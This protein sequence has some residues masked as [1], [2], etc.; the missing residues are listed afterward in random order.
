MHKIY[1][2]KE[3]LTKFRATNTNRAERHESMWNQLLD[4]SKSNQNEMGPMLLACAEYQWRIPAQPN[5]NTNH[6]L[7]CH[8]FYPNLLILEGNLVSTLS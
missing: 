6:R 3:S 4:R 1:T 7:C 5:L 2:T 8:N